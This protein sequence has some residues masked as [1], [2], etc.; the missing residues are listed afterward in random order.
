MHQRGHRD[1]SAHELL[2]LLYLKTSTRSLRQNFS[3]VFT[4]L[5]LLQDS[6]VANYLLPEQLTYLFS[7]Q[8][9]HSASPFRKPLSVI[10]ALATK[11]QVSLP[12]LS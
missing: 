1:I 5:H 4:E 10:A 8:S 11:L 7:T 6:L 12:L 3:L 9:V 2:L